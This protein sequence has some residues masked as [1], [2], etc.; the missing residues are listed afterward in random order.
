MKR[1]QPRILKGFRDFPPEKQIPRLQCIHTL[2]K[3]FQRFGY[4]PI[5]T[6]ILEYEE[7]LLGKGGGETEKQVYTFKDKGNRDVAMRFD[8][9]V[10]LARY[11][12]M[13]KHELPIPF[14]RYQIGKVFRGEN[15][16]RGRYREFMQCD[17]DIIG[18]DHVSADV[19]TIQTI[20]GAMQELHIPA[21]KV[22]ISHRGLLDELLSQYTPKKDI[23]HQQALIETLRII[24]KIRKIGPQNTLELL[25]S[26]WEEDVCATI[27]AFGEIQANNEDTL[28]NIRAILPEESQGLLRLQ[29]IYQIIESLEL[30]SSVVI[31]PSITRGL[32][33]Y[34][35]FVC[36]TFI[37]GYEDVG[38]VCSGGRYDNLTQMFE[39]ELFPGVGA[40]VGL[41][42]LL[43][44]LELQEYT[45]GTD[46]LSRVA[47]FALD[48]ES[49]SYCH[50]LIPIFH[51]ADIGT[52]MY[53]ASHNL[54]AFFKYS[55]RVCA[56]Y[57]CIIGSK[58][59]ETH[60]VM[61]KHQST[62]E[63]LT[64]VSIQEAIKWITHVR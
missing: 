4:Q 11:V 19:T 60:T 57:V 45:I 33:Y 44:I 15:T 10:P 48:E 23:S 9:T 31:N 39:D 49:I 20:I 2:Q 37:T 64:Q 27:L 38:S 5:D 26:I 24:D 8:L 53:A 50:Q 32:D 14:A 62:R 47:I 12:A 13:H 29:T 36:E 6:P 21:I 42:R 46:V 55:E 34:T 7:I 22:H 43:A 63:Q 54:K 61:V 3:V 17:F 40:S 30:T 28:Q 59:R 51:T 52:F 18:Q 56:D 16:Q 35:G 1:I 41:D 25:Q 58:E